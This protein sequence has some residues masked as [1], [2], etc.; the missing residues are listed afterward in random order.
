MKRYLDRL[1][2][3][4]EKYPDRPALV[5]AEKSLTYRGL[6]IET[7]KIFNYL[8][9][10]GVKRDDHIMVCP[11]RGI[12]SVSCILGVL[13]AGAAFIPL[14]EDYPQE[15]VDYIKK[16]AS[17]TIVLD[18]ALYRKILATEE[19]R[20]GHEEAELHDK[21]YIIYT[22]GSTGNPKG[23]IHEYGNIEQQASLI[24]ERTDWREFRQGII[25]PFYFMATCQFVMHYTLQAFTMYILPG[26]IVRNIASFSQYMHENRIQGIFLSPSY[27]RLYKEPSPYLEEILTAGEPAN[28][29]YYP[30]GK[31]AIRNL[32]GMTEAGFTILETFL[33]KAY[34][35]APMG[36]PVLAEIDLHL[37]DEQGNRVEGAGT[38]EICFK[39]EYVRGY[40]NL[41]EKTKAAFVEGVFHTGDL[42]RRDE[43]GMYYIVGRKDD[44]FK[45]NGNRVEPVEIE[46]AVKKITGLE[47]VVA[48]GFEL[49]GRSFICLYYLRGE[50]AELNLLAGKELKVD[51][52]ALADMLP[53]YML[54]TYYIPLEEMPL[55]DRGKILRRLL[56]AP[57]LKDMAGEY[58][59][60]TNEA[61]RAICEMM[62]EI[63]DLE[64]FSAA[65]DFFR[66]GGDSLRSIRL[67]ALAGS[68]G[69]SF[70][71]GELYDARTPRR[72]AA[73]CANRQMPGDAAWQLQELQARQELRELLSMQK[74]WVE[75]TLA[76]AEQ[77]MGWIVRFYK[78][79]PSV[80]P[81]RLREALDKVLRHYPIFST[82]LARGED[83][84]I[85][86]VY[87]ESL[88]VPT[89]I[90]E[91]TEAEIDRLQQAPLE[92]MD[93]F[94]QGGY[95]GKILRTKETSYLF[96]QLHHAF[97]DGTGMALLRD[98]LFEC[99][100][101]PSFEPAP[102][103]YYYLLRQMELAAASEVYREAGRYYEELYRQKLQLAAS[104]CKMHPDWEGR[105]Q[106]AVLY[107]KTNAFP[108][109]LDRTNAFY[110]TAAA[111]AM[112]KS[113]GTN[114]SLVY[115]TSNGRDESLKMNSAGGF[116]F[117]VPVGLAIGEGNTPEELLAQTKAQMEFG[118][119]HAPYSY[120]PLDVPSMSESVLFLYQ[121]DMFGLGKMGKYIE[122]QLP[123]IPE[124]EQPWHFFVISV[125]DQAE[126]DRLHLSVIYS[127]HHFSADKVEMFVENYLEAVDYLSDG[128]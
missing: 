69:F 45:I 77:N 35:I 124:F 13:K 108:R 36:K 27:V 119:A 11:K 63:L 89:E 128:K 12:G 76:H 7:G 38:G 112:A 121:K 117:N 106:K 115:V 53:R 122:Q 97:L 87:D 18:E 58:V 28:G 101:N 86:Q 43:N 104:E 79:K 75:L 126:D 70:T 4:M 19:Y 24:E 107:R 51:L 85:R 110:T 30:G 49:E 57:E 55:S 98:N 90:R 66:L 95:R 60:P 9:R 88:P 56:P 17:C 82:R 83:G 78:M 10:Q 118:V 71:A 62:A 47:T 113:N 54:P 123:Y 3:I 42:G 32:Y 50:A 61:E 103:Y 23:S 80:D 74:I 96:L 15:R 105:H 81:E 8:K 1:H 72:L 127:P 114:H 99:Y 48:K 44:M 125:V 37:E 41:P 14:E 40:L 109:K 93:I 16:D 92:K 100:E 94:A 84:V 21:A 20:E 5:E 64:K 102:D 25:S 22:S 46:S 39:N 6:E 33:D 91:V 67:I 26:D 52:G 111:L 59:A 31:P 34:E 65:S 68:R 2:E 116:A 73:I 120:F 29:L